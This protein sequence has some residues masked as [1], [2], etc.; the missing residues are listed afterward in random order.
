[1]LSYDG[2]STMPMPLAFSVG[3]CTRLQGL[4]RFDFSSLATTGHDYVVGVFNGSPGWVV[5]TLYSVKTTTNPP[6]AIDLKHMFMSS[7]GFDGVTGASSTH[8]DSAMCSKFSVRLRNTSKAI[9]VGGVVRVLNMSA[10]ADTDLTDPQNFVD[11]I[12][13]VENHASVTTFGGEELRATQQW[14]THPVDQ[15]RYAQFIS[16][17]K[18]QADAVDAIKDPAMSTIVMVIPTFPNNTYELT[19]KGHYYARY[20]VTGALANMASHP[21]VADLTLLNRARDQAESL[22]SRGYRAAARIEGYAEPAIGA[23]IGRVIGRAIE[24]AAF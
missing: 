3:R 18:T 21:P 11:L 22:G 4:A 20:R 13:Y 24:A 8:P 14:D 7:A 9:D 12:R 6:L 2:F 15:S 10:G 17:G 16:P 19:A 1:M 5:G 23:S